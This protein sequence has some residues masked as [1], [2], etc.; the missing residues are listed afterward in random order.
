MTYTENIQSVSTIIR[1]RRDRN[2]PELALQ[3]TKKVSTIN[4]NSLAVNV[5]VDSKHQ[6]CLRHVLVFPRSPSRD[7][8]LLAIPFSVDVRFVSFVRAFGRHLGGEDAWGNAA[9]D[10]CKKVLLISINK[11]NNE[12]SL[13]ENSGEARYAPVHADFDTRLREFLCKQGVEVNRSG[14]GDVVCR[15]ML[16]G[17][18]DATH[19]RSV[20][21][22]STT[23][24][25]GFGGRCE[26]G[27]ECRRHE[28]IT[29]VKVI[30]RP[31]RGMTL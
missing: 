15:M 20:N 5:V 1:Y 27:E 30:V 21:D 9:L 6:N 29:M 10:G 8:F 22:T 18:S 25:V 12:G 19:R 4:S 13:E 31:H 26:E 17:A 14:L 23:P 2:S 16:R 28:I 11:I 7:H 3:L 24:R